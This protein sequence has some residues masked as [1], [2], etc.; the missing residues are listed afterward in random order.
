MVLSL[1]SLFSMFLCSE[2]NFKKQKPKEN[3]RML[4]EE[5]SEMINKMISNFSK[6]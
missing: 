2:N 6:H 5:T 1:F 4:E 3:D